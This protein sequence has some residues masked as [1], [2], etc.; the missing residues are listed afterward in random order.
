MERIHAHCVPGGVDL[1]RPPGRLQHPE[2]RL[3]LSRVAPKR[4][5]GLL[6]SLPV[7]PIARG[8]QVL[9]PRKRGQG[10]LLRAAGTLGHRR[11]V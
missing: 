11:Q 9:D 1:R 5:E 3:E 4:I 6:H 8:R 10:R 2:L 7:V